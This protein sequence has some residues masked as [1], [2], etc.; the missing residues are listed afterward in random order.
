MTSSGESGQSQLLRGR[1]AKWAP[2]IKA[3]I[4]IASVEGEYLLFS[5]HH[6]CCVTG[7]R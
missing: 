2:Q 5:S 6:S 4:V 1:V 3:A 7:R